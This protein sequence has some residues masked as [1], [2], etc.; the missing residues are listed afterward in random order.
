MRAEVLV[1]VK[2]AVDEIIS[3]DAN[4]TVGVLS[5]TTAIKAL[6]ADMIPGYNPLDVDLDNTSVTTIHRGDK[7]WEIVAV[8]DVMHLENLERRACRELEANHDPRDRQLRQ[9]HLQP[10]PVSSASS[11]RRCEVRPQR[12]RSRVDEID[13]LKPERIVMSPG[14]CTPNEA[15]VSL[16][17]IRALGRPHADPRRLPRPPVHRPGVRRRG[18]A[19]ADDHARQDRLIH[20]DGDGVFARRAQ[21]VRGDALPLAGRRA[22]KRC[23]SAR[24]DGVD[25]RRRDHGPAPPR[26]IRSKACSSIPKAS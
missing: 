16:D 3:K 6:L 18:R 24:G 8:D 14:P 17:V 23:R 25:R 13:A 12:R 5:H 21:P 15:G 22:R 10:R 19:R 20:H 9:L 26:R 1:R 4:E 2:V 11:A 7:G